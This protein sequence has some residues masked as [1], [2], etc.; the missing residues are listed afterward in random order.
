MFETIDYPMADLF[1]SAEQS[2]APAPCIVASK[3]SPVVQPAKCLQCG[4]A[5]DSM[6]CSGKCRDKFQAAG[7]RFAAKLAKTRIEGEQPLF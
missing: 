4:R 7:D 1:E 2:P 6:F 3:P 5:S